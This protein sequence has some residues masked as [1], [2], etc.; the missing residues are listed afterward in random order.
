MSTDY[1]HHGIKSMHCVIGEG[2][3]KTFDATDPIYFRV[4]VYFTTIDIPN[5]GADRRVD[6]LD[7]VYVDWHYCVVVDLF[8]FAG[9]IYWGMTYGK[10]GVVLIVR[11]LIRHNGAMV[12]C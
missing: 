11:G 3:Y 9:T 5:P 8:N 1:A 10:L 4:Y 2:V 12:L 6:L 7:I